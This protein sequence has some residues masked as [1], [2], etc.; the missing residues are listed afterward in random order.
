MQPETCVARWLWV[1]RRTETKPDNKVMSSPTH[2]DDLPPEGYTDHHEP[3]D[4]S[5]DVD[6][7]HESAEEVQDVPMSPPPVPVEHPDKIEARR[8]LQRPD[9]IME[10][11]CFDALKT[12]IRHKGVPLET[13]SF[14]SDNYVGYAELCNLVSQW[15]RH[16]GS[17]DDEILKIVEDFFKQLVK[18]NFTVDKTDDLFR[19]NL[20]VRALNLLNYHE[21]AFLLLVVSQNQSQRPKCV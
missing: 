8:K 3:K 15:L 2:G 9:G 17:T 11:D 10:P 12:Y 18:D 19:Q 6:R 7:P 16:L 20:S 13:I 4:D 5:M 1:L 21:H 14:L